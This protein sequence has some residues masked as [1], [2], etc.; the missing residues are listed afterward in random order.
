M[1]EPRNEI[2]L[3]RDK[4]GLIRD[5]T[6]SHIEVKAVYSPK[7]LADNVYER[8]VGDPG[9]FPY[10]RGIYP[11]MFRD[12][13][14]LKSFIVSYATEEETN[15]AFKSYIQNGLNDLRLLADLPTQSGLDP[16]HPSSWNSMMCGGVAHYNLHS[17]EKMLE[18]LPLEGVTYETAHSNVSNAIFT[19]S[20]LV[21]LMENQGMDPSKLRGNGICD[22]IRAKLVYASPDW[23]TEINRQICLDHVEYC[24]DNTPKWKAVAPNGVDPCQAGMNAVQE[25]GEV[26]AVATVVIDDLVKRGRTLDQYGSMVVSMDSESDFFETIAKFRAGRRMWA[27]IAKERFGAKTAKACQMKIGIRTSGL[28]LQWQKP[29]NNASR[30]TLQ[31]LSSVLGGVNSIDASS[32]DEA[33]GLPSYEAR[34]FGLDTQHII[35]HEANIPLVAD[36]LG[37]SYYLEWL[38]DKIEAETN[39]YLGEIEKRGGIYECLSTGWLN[40]VMEQNR[41][42]VQREEAQGKRLLVGVNSFKGEEGPINKAVANCAYKVPNEQARHDKVAESIAFKKSRDLPK[43]QNCLR[44]LFEDAKAKRNVSR[45]IIEGL[46]AGM[47]I[48]EMTGIVRL[49]YGLGYDPLEA[50]PTPAYIE[51]MKL[52]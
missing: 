28:S 19:Q 8:D 43:L 11:R 42:K 27:K 21:A 6:Q 47:T 25:L 45:A 39:Q 30:V 40:G 41:L 49:A 1:S 36:P 50:L 52:K 29:L 44:R 18:G 2:K 17:F 23:P 37:G 7:D 9:Q 48:G 24:M 51:E 32:I 38:T 16:D 15:T 4:D 13:L 46:K 3:E 12:R 34:M 20:A 26:I 22:P 14:W 10:T 5:A 35:T 33:I 31:I